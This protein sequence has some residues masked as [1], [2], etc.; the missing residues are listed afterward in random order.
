MGYRQFL[1][2]S[3]LFGTILTPP[4]AAKHCYYYDLTDTQQ[5]VGIL[6]HCGKEEDC[7][8]GQGIARG[9]SHIISKSCV[10]A[11]NCGRELSVDYMGVTYKFMTYCCSEELCNASPPGP[12]QAEPDRNIVAASVGLVLLLSWLL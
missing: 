8:Q 4:V 10:E 1:Y 9:I 7:Y 5:C 6:M 2:L 3:L 12:M 11:T